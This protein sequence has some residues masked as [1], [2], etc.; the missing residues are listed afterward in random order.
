LVRWGLRKDQLC[1]SLRSCPDAR[2]VSCRSCGQF[3]EPL[4]QRHP[5]PCPACGHR[6]SQRE[7]C[8]RCLQKKFQEGLFSEAGQLLLRAFDFEAALHMKLHLTL[9]DVTAEEFWALNVLRLERDAKQ[10]EDM[11]A[12]QREN[13]RK[14]RRMSGNKAFSDQNHPRQG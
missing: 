12:E 7:R 11:E 10:R 1:P 2:Q 8:P 6:Q 9:D 13:E 4:D 5:E 14:Q 3:W